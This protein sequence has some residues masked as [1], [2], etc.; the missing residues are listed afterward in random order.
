MKILEEKKI[1]KFFSQQ[2]LNLPLAGN[3]LYS[4]HMKINNN[5]HSVYI[6]LGIITKL[7][8]TKYIHKRT[9]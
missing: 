5:L 7:E 3:Y 8:I 2:N 4:T 6:V 9:V 1:P